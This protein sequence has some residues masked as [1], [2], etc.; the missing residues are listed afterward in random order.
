MTRVLDGPQPA[1]ELTAALAA[2][3]GRGCQTKR[4]V[5]SAARH[6]QARGPCGFR[7]GVDAQ[8]RTAR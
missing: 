2:V 3:K 4:L 8:A 1:A 5:I 6:I 7:A